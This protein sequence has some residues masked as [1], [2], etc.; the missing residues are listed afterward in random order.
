M[1]RYHCCAAAPQHRLASQPD[2]ASFP[3]AIGLAGACK[4]RLAPPGPRSGRP[5]S[6]AV[7]MMVIV[8]RRLVFRAPVL[9]VA[10]PPRALA[11]PI[12][13]PST[14]TSP[15]LASSKS[16]QSPPAAKAAPRGA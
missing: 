13:A 6:R 1:Q 4:V 10:A 9:L 14:R 15:V 8:Q 11:C 5:A 16:P 12:L 2:L 3:A 7:R